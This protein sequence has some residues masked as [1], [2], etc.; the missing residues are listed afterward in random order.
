MPNFF[1]V[2]IVAEVICFLV[3]LICLLKA[4]N[5]VWRSM[6]LYLLLTCVTEITG[7]YIAK[8]TQNNHW[9]YNIFLFFEA[10]FTF[11]MLANLLGK[12][13]NCKPIIIPGVAIF[14]VFYVYGFINHGVYF[15]N[16]AAYTVISVMFVLYSLYYYYLLLKDDVYIDLKYSPEFWWVAGTLL[17][18]FANT[19]CNIFYNQLFSIMISPKHHLTYFIFKALNIILYG[20]WSYAFICKKW[21]TTTSEV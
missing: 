17:F 8:Q 18:Y 13:V 2:S 6:V 15:Y 20:C 14:I 5:L 9:L 3:A 19:G 21:L 10:G 7:L 1:T 4:Q 12:Y 11:L 16:Y